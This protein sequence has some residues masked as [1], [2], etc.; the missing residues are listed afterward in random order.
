MQVYMYLF[1]SACVY[2]S[3]YTLHILYHI[4]DHIYNVY[5]FFILDEQY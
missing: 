2:K 5:V 1:V 3:T 4:I